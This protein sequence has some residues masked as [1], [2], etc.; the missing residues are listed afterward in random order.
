[1]KEQ[2]GDVSRETEAQQRHGWT[3]HQIDIPKLFKVYASSLQN[4]PQEKAH[5]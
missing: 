2:L 3:E 1:M 4:I 5:F